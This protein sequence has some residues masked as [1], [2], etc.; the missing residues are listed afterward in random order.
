ME[1]P[2]PAPMSKYE[3]SVA[4][5]RDSLEAS[6]LK[7]LASARL[8]LEAAIAD[9]R[10]ATEKRL[11]KMVDTIEEIDKIGKEYKPNITP[12]QVVVDIYEK[13]SRL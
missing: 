4:E 9:L 8:K 7:N 10:S 3:K 2:V 6:D 13:A 1:M 11:S 5:A 12:H